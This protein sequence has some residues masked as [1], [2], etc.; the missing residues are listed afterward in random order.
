MGWILPNEKPDAKTWEDKSI[1]FFSF[2]ED[3]EACFIF[4]AHLVKSRVSN[5]P[6]EQPAMYPS[7][8]WWNSNQ[9]R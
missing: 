7:G 8:S 3:I 5:I 1:Y 4:A 6:A 2:V 9:V